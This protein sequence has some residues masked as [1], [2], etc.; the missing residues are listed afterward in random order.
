MHTTH[1]VFSHCWGESHYFVP[2]IGWILLPFIQMLSNCCVITA[3]YHENL[4]PCHIETHVA[5]WQKDW[6][7]W[8]IYY[9]CSIGHCLVWNMLCLLHTLCEVMH[10]QVSWSAS[11]FP[12]FVTPYGSLSLMSQKKSKTPRATAE[13]FRVVV[14]DFSRRTREWVPW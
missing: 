4:H 11:L 1:V 6:E 10:S 8:R 9:P 12:P 2:A 7:N 14:L 3:H 13:I 5:L